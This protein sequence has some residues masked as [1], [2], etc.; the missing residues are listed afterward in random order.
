MREAFIC[1]QRVPPRGRQFSRHH[2]R[3]LIHAIQ[4][5]L[6][7]PI[8]KTLI[9]LYQ[10]LD[11]VAGLHPK[12][13]RT[14]EPKEDFDLRKQKQRAIIKASTLLQ[15]PGQ[16]IYTDASKGLDDLINNQ[17]NEPG[18]ARRIKMLLDAIGLPLASGD[19]IASLALDLRNSISH[20]LASVRVKDAPEDDGYSM[21]E[22]VAVQL[23]LLKWAH[24]SLSDLL[25]VASES[26]VPAT[27][28]PTEEPAASKNST[29]KQ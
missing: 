14:K 23:R 24:R 10:V 26:P 13:P 18:V 1:L 25:W 11:T 27:A 9:D 15:P 20:N 17:K 22:L 7:S 5:A 28:A 19:R 29:G 6:R 8:Q 2:F 12:V 3:V 21:E 4:V 16:A